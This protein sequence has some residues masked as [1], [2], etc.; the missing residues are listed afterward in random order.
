MA[1]LLSL[2]LVDG[3]YIADIVLA[4]VSLLLLDI[5]LFYFLRRK[6]VIVFTL[7]TEAVFVVAIALGMKMLALSSLA[8]FLVGTIVFLFINMNEFRHFFSNKITDRSLVG[9]LLQ[10]KRKRK[11]K[12]EI[13]IDRDDLNKK[14]LRAVSDMSRLKRGAL[15]TFIKND[16]ILDDSKSSFVRQRGVDINAPFSVELV[17]TIFYEGTRLHDGAIVVRG[18]MIE[19]A[20]VFFVSTGRPLTG[21]YGSRHQAAIGISEN[22]DSVTVVVSEETGRIAIAFHGELM[23]VTPDNFLRVFD[24]CMSYESESK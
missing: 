13:I 16:D 9:R 23:A 12:S 22:S 14:V 8:A 18:N 4:S 24:E 11:V 19:R 5:V 3:F 20:S 7:V 15:M 10:P 6:L 1:S 21:K 2:P 17:E